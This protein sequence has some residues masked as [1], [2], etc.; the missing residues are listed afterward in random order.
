MRKKV[1]TDGE[2]VMKTNGHR[3][4]LAMAALMVGLA[5]NPAGAQDLKLWRHGIVEA[6]SDAG[7]VFMGSK[8]GFAE[9]QGLKI[10]IKQ[11]KGDA[12]ALK[13]LI[14]GELD[15]YEGSPGSPMIAVSRG[16]D[17]KLIGCYWPGLTYA[18]YSK[19]SIATPADLKGKTLAISAPGALP[20]LLARAVLEQNN[21]TAAEVKFAAMGSD[22]DRF[23]AL[24]AG[25][26]DAAAAST[27]FAPAAAKAGIKMLVNGS[28]DVPNFMR[29]CTYSTSKTL[30][31]RK[32]DSI[33]FLAAEMA[34]IRYALANRDKTIALTRE[35]TSAKADNPQPAFIYDEVKRLSAVDPD[36]AIPMN[37][38]TWMRDLL[39]KTGNLTKPVDLEAFVDGSVR[40]DALKKISK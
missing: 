25:I 14:A 31:A 10:E 12:L 20:D 15:S 19:K 35:V 17:V 29:F 3:W 40:V 22:A 23:K 27:G 21:L 33:H 24:S 39:V 37:K 9:K 2:L 36:M 5:V 32:D 6:K 38:L 11:F 34:G 8:G 18:I 30:A 28:E 16:A 26:V 7:I 13:A 1:N 4:M